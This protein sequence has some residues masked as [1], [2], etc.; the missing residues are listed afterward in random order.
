MLLFRYVAAHYLKYIVVILFALVFFMVGFDFI[1]VAKDLPDSANLI[2]IYVVFK[3]FFAVDM[4]LPLSLV[5]AMIATKIQMIRTNA[6]VALY[7]LGY[8]KTDLL[9]PF[10]VVS[11]AL[12]VLYIGLHTTAFA[13]ADEYANNIRSTSQFF[14]P[15]NHLFF[16]YQD[17]Y[18]YFGRL[19]PLKERA[20]DIRI[21]GV[22]KGDLRFV[23]MADE[24]RYKHGYWHIDEAKRITKPELLS[25]SGEG[26]RMTQERG[27]KL[28]K[29]FRP[30]ILDQV[31][32]G[33]VNYT[34]IDAID[35]MRLLQDQNVNLDR[36]KSALY[37]MFVH[38]LFVP[39]LIVILF[40][41]VPASPRFLNL[42]LFSFGA[43]LATLTVWALL[44]M[45]IELSNNKTIPS[46]AGVV[47]P[48]VLLTLI[49]VW[50]WN[51]NRLQAR[52]A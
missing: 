27:L 41:F 9:R 15:T 50:I 21:F 43:I 37:R 36:I 34:I 40:F 4:M 39:A 13:R 29:D 2:L 20:Y 46:E 31:Y 11:G 22:E 26:A 18:I 47:M 5:F 48:V 52:R 33:K 14:K 12:I 25:L 16:T 45:M 10:V 24:A 49:A 38:P 42:S 17:Q 44:F 51:Q 1:Q 32:E 6:L 19:D 30:K 3:A 23:V 28:L 35:A 7:A 8:T